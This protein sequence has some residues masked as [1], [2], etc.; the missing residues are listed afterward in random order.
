MENN[1]KNRFRVGDIIGGISGA[2]VAL[3]QSMGL[4]I[5]LFSVMGYSAAE[6]ALAGLIGATVLLL[7]S[8][9]VGA[10]TAMISA[11]NGPMTMMLVGVMTTLANSGASS[12]AMALNLSAIL[13]TM[14]VFQ[15]IFAL[16]GGAQLIKYIPYPVIAGLVTGVGLL[17]VKSQ[18]ELLAKGWGGE[19]P[20][21]FD[22]FYPTIIA[23]LTMIAMFFIPKIT[24]GKIPGAVGGL[25]IGI[26]LFYIGVEFF[27]LLFDKEWVVGTIPSIT[28][29]HFGIPLNEI[30]SLSF[31]LII[32]TALALTVLGMTDGL[33]TSLVADSR[34]GLHHN[35]KLE[36]VAQG[37][38][39][40]VIGLSGALGGWGTKGATLVTIE[41]GGR[42][43]APII[44]GL[45]FLFL[46]IFAGEVGNYLP[47]SVLAGIVAMVGI[48]MIDWNILEW[49]RHKRTRL[50]AITAIGVIVII[51]SVNLVVAVGV[52]VLFSILLFISMQTKEPIV[53]R[54]VSA[55]EYRSIVKRSEEE[56]SIL[57]KYG[58][59]I[60]MYELKGNLF[61][62]TAD[63]LRREISEDI[64][65]DRIVILHFRRVKYID[66]SAMIVLLQLGEDGKKKGCEFI[67]CHLHKGLGFGKKTAKAFKQ[68]DKKRDFDYKVFRDTDTAFEY[69]ENR[70]ISMH[71]ISNIRQESEFSIYENSIFSNV[72][73]YYIDKIIPILKRKE[74]KKNKYLFKGK[75]FGDSIIMIEKGCIEIRLQIKKREYKR[76]AKYEPGTFFGE[77]SFINPGPRITDAIAIEDSVV[78]ELKKD[79]IKQY[80]DEEY[81]ELLLKM[82]NIISIRLSKELRKATATVK[83]LEEW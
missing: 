29:M 39:E 78:Y 82:L 15:I 1:I 79:D 77:L 59:N 76:L 65:R 20:S 37:T 51:I 36:M 3:P 52:G 83:R 11:P 22:K 2:A 71:G 19:I 75:D 27:S 45:F 74:I 38:S 9:G 21:S 30:S 32:S 26:I 35:S 63:K 41:A 25:I 33:I 81:Y 13:I 50:D 28:N 44:A 62:A 16:L 47:V 4:G 54:K 58:D 69:A 40:I 49:I 18:I 43:Y 48:G 72:D 8:G 34:T 73:K 6:G 5:V 80:R 57:D 66:M 42:R 70:L 14:G 68:I 17:M 7:I 12:S 67:F 23:I 24:K 61:F 64:E 10:T 46:M 55:K 60:I 53:H 56:N 31:E